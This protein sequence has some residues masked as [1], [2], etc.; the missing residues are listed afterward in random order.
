MRGMVFS[1]VRPVFVSCSFRA[2]AFHPNIFARARFCANLPG[3]GVMGEKAFVSVVSGFIFSLIVSGCNQS[4]AAV[5]AIVAITVA[6]P[7]GQPPLP[8]HSPLTPFR[9]VP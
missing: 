4:G 9:V 5:F 3:A 1:C 6:P 7:L 8:G 2:R